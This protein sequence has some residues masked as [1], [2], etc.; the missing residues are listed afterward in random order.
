MTLCHV[1]TFME[2]MD[3]VSSA[4]SAAVS[5]SLPSE[6]IVIIVACVISIQI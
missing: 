6:G 2:T 4:D 3:L 5:Q 1:F